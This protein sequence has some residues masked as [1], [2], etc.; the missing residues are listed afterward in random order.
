MRGWGGQGGRG[1][2]CHMAITATA[3]TTM[4][5][6]VSELDT[7]IVQGKRDRKWQREKEW[8]RMGKWWWGRERGKR[9][10]EKRES[11]IEWE[12]KSERENLLREGTGTWPHLKRVMNIAAKSAQ[13]LKCKG[14][15]VCVC[16]RVSVCASLLVCVWAI[17]IVIFLIYFNLW[18][19]YMRTFVA[20]TL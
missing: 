14:N 16:V 6:T 20:A 7:R 13:S 10:E 5:Q 4:G 18:D 3:A 15:K 9:K 17:E 2:V 8:D 1:N 11:G 12:G 19:F